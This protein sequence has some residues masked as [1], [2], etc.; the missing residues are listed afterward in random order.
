MWVGKCPN[1]DTKLKADI[2]NSYAV[3]DGDVA[4]ASIRSV[5]LFLV[6]LATVAGVIFGAIWVE[7][8]ILW[9]GIS[10]AVGIIVF[11]GVAAYRR[12]EMAE[13]YEQFSDSFLDSEDRLTALIFSGAALSAMV[14][15]KLFL[16]VGTTSWWIWTAISGAAAVITGVFLYLFR[17]DDH[18][19]ADEAG[20]GFGGIIF[21]VLF[22][23]KGTFWVI[24]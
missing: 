1:C 2:V 16:L 18:Y 4:V 6:A 7:S 12:K 13:Y 11:L 10:L 14:L 23:L 19:D 15:F 8:W 5:A 21:I 17:K 20:L 3:S 22:I 9:S 24:G